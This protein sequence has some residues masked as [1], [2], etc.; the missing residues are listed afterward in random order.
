MTELMM[1]GIAV[2]ILLAML[3]LGLL[4]H[5]QRKSAEYRSQLALQQEQL[6]GKDR[7]IN[8]IRQHEQELQQE[9]Q[10][11]NAA[12]ISHREEIAQLKTLLTQEQQHSVEKLHLLQQ[13]KEQMTLEF[14]QL[15]GDILEEKSQRFTQSNQEN[16]TRILQPLGERISTFEKKVQ[17]T[18]QA[19]ARERHS[20]AN[21][22]RNLQELNAR[23]STD[24][25]NLTRALK[26]E[27]KTQ[28][29]W[30]EVILKSI[31]EKSGLVKGR[32]YEE[33]AS[34]EAEDGRR[35]Q[36]DVIVHLPDNKQV[37]ID[38][39]VSLKAYENYCS[40]EDDGKRAEHL[41]QHVLS[42]RNHVK[43]L[44]SKSYQN[45]KALN[46]LDFVLLFMPVEAAFAVAVHEDGSLFSEAF[47]RNI[48]LVGPSTLL[49]TLR[50]IQNI[51]RYERQSQ[52]AIEIANSAGNLYD[53]FVAF[54]ED[55]ED[56]GKKIQATQ[57]SYDR[58]HNKLH[59]G[60][61]NLL[62]RVEKLRELGARASKKHAAHILAQAD[63]SELEAQEDIPDRIEEGGAFKSEPDSTDDRD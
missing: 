31:L 62:S 32:E 37:I 54:V 50:A 60:K 19:E 11:L 2:I 40:E 51:W 22:I 34:L 48:I 47:D 59:T 29:T 61:G 46:S 4:F 25:I 35:S 27:S 10:T 30:G 17:E 55:I 49:A 16:L 39:K 45:L 52:H 43:N 53:K 57:K 9:L 24:A 13:A 5:L 63:L 3:S 14:K 41:R 58:A 21:E 7:E 20:L 28:G 36:P 6:D 1:A 18:Y 42:I 8:T 12:N 38:A 33:Q 15:A 23:I 44:G 56:I 26:G